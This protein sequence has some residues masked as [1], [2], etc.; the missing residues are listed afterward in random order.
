MTPHYRMLRDYA[1]AVTGSLIQRGAVRRSRGASVE[2]VLRSE[3]PAVLKEIQGD[4]AQLAREFG[5]GLALT[6][7]EALG[8]LA[9]QAVREFAAVGASVISDAL[10]GG[11]GRG[12]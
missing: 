7:P 6:I 2:D 5:A 1:M 3:G 4:L 10:A 11:R 9:Q 8:T 12:R